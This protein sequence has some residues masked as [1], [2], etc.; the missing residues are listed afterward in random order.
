MFADCV[1]YRTITN[2]S[3]QQALQNDL[4]CIQAWCDQWLMTLNPTKCK[5][6]SFSR[7]R[8]PLSFSYAVGNVN[9]ECRNI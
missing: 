5:S 6:V 3:E 8:N 2:P 1:V 7:R 4:N 9:V